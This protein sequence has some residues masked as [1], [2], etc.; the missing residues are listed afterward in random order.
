MNTS[1]SAH[2]LQGFSRLWRGA[3]VLLI[4]ALVAL[5]V[6]C[7]SDSPGERAAD[8]GENDFG[9]ETSVFANADRT[10]TVD[11]VVNAGW[12]KSREL[13]AESLEGA[14]EVWF[15]FFQQ[16]NLEVRVYS[17]HDEAKRLGTEPAEEVVKRTRGVS[18][19]GA[20]PYMKQT[21]QYGGYGVIGNLLVLCELEVAVC[22]DLATA[23]SQ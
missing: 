9:F 22:D 11:D 15:G 13:P 12:K 6:A 8:A 20:G 3:P 10:Y 14:S 17:S 18:D 23:L 5:A 1:T 4:A 16:K 21:T 7:G 2:T 19:G